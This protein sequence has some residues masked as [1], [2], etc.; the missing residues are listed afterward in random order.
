VAGCRGGSLASERHDDVGRV[1]EVSAVVAVGF[2][3][4][5][6]FAVVLADLRVSG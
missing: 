1:E 5:R 2:R 6:T 3:A 4:L